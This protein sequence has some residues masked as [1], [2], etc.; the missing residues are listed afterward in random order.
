MQAEASPVERIRVTAGLRLDA[1][2]YD[3]DDGLV[4][5]KKGNWSSVISKM[6]AAIKGNPK[7][8]DRVRTY[9]MLTINYHPYYYRGVAYMQTGRYEEA[10]SDFERTYHAG[11]VSGRLS[12]RPR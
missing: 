3:Y 7:E 9:G 12:Q 6:T 2:G 1:L 10:I 4:A 11:T 8:G 5:A